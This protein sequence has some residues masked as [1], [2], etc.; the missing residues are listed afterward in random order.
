LSLKVDHFSHH[1]IRCNDRQTCPHHHNHCNQRLVIPHRT[2]TSNASWKS[3]PQMQM[4]LCRSCSFP[5]NLFPLRKFPYPKYRMCSNLN[6]H[7]HQFPLHPQ[8]VNLSQCLHHQLPPQTLPTPRFLLQFT[9]P[10]QSQCLAYPLL[11]TSTQSPHS[12]SRTQSLHQPLPYP[13]LQHLHQ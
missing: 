11:L 7:H 8:P 1:Q 5:K 12:S 9:L 13:L 4:N 2:P 3:K 6:P 10:Q